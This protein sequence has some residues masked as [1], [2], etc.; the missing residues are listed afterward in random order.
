MYARTHQFIDFAATHPNAVL[1]FLASDMYF[2]AHTDVSYLSESKARL[3]CGGF[4]F[5][6]SKTNL[7]INSDDPAPP[8]ND[9]I[10]TNSSIIDT[11]MSSA[12]EAETGAGFFNAQQLVPLRL[13]LE[14]LGHKQGLTP[15]QFDNKVATSIINDKISQRRSKAMDMRFY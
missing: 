3:R 7:P 6:S 9:P 11:V 8:I 15:L 14:E 12:Q 13:A 10:A 5:L 2:W 4:Y 1:T